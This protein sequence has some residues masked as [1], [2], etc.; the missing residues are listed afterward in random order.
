MNI[1]SN[2]TELPAKG[3]IPER[4]TVQTKIIQVTLKQIHHNVNKYLHLSTGKK[5]NRM[6]SVFHNL[7]FSPYG[8]SNLPHG[9]MFDFTINCP[10]LWLNV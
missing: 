6:P 1:L 4:M 3:Q 5:C 7:V 8:F 2:P 10:I 9:K